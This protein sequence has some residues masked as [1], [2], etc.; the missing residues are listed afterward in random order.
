MLM[1]YCPNDLFNLL[2]GNTNVTEDQMLRYMHDIL[3]AI[4]ACHDR[5]IAHNDIKPSNFLLDKYGRIK[6]CDFG[7]SRMYDEHCMSSCYRGTML[8]MAPELFKKS[9][10]NPLKADIWSIGI[11]FFY[12][13][14]RSFPFFAADKQVYIKSLNS[15]IYPQFIVQ[16]PQLRVLI[17]SCLQVNPEAR[18]TIDE[19]LQMPYF[20]SYN[21]SAF[22]MKEGIRLAC[23]QNALNMAPSYQR[24]TKLSSGRCSLVPI[25]KPNMRNIVN[26]K[27][28]I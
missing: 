27:A 12:I 6:M 3:I 26:K 25:R 1:E 20:D 15:G 11:T 14:T 17:Q 23:S 24:L 22:R 13:A 2:K 18:P 16:N 5:N 28:T 9:P 10:Y 8:F 21:S 7:L 4:K 19:L